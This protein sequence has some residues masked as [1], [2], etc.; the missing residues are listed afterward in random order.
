MKKIA[1]LLL[2]TLIGVTSLHAQIVNIPDADFKFALTNI[3]LVDTDGDLIADAIADT[4][5][6]GEIQVNE[7]LV[8]ERLDA[9]N[10]NCCGLNVLSFEGIEAFSNLTYLDC[11]YNDLESLDVS[12]NTQLVYLDA[13]YNLVP[14]Y[15]FSNNLLLEELFLI[16]SN[17]TSVDVSQNTA[18]TWLSLAANDLTSID[19]SQLPNLD[20]LSIGQN[21]ITE[22]DVTNN[23][24]LTKLFINGNPMTTVD[25]SQNPLFEWL[26]ADFSD[27]E[28]IDLSNNPNLQRFEAR[29]TR[30]TELDLRNNPTV[31]SIYL[32]DNGNL[33]TLLVSNGNN[34]MID[35]LILSD[36]VNLSCVEVD[37]VPFALA[38]TCDGINDGWC[39]DDPN[40]YSDFC[41][42]GVEDNPAL[43]VTLY[44][45]PAIELLNVASQ[46]A[47][48]QIS[49]YSLEGEL[50]TS[51]ANTNSVDVS[52]L[53]NGMY[54]AKIVSGTQ[55]SVQ[56][57]VKQ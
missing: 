34:A 48:D 37:D 38:Q 9:D 45:N 12:Q 28:T 54:F 57:F 43:T 5:G 50:I 42:L 20:R 25:L 18:L 35:D 41:G 22:V 39:I 6:D 40:L 33:T 31:E 53:S 23:P 44:P 47:V 24:V 3:P 4:N 26:L 56:K 7:A 10:L 27:L 16:N 2:L 46:A 15:D 55:T 19:V 17:Q 36:C 1:T 49:V 32:H 30:L 51:K 29:D 8:V 13:R 11:A 21:P 14:S 52:S